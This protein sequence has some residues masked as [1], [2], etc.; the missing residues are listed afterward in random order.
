MED[1]KSQ[2][3]NETISSPTTSSQTT[4]EN[5]ASDSENSEKG[6]S[7]LHQALKRKRTDSENEHLLKRQ[8]YIATTSTNYFNSNQ[9]QQQLQQQQ[10]QQ[11][12]RN[13]VKPIF[14]KPSLLTSALTSPPK[15]PVFHLISTN[16]GTLKANHHAELISLLKQNNLQLNSNAPSSTTSITSPSSSSSSALIKPKEEVVTIKS[17]D[18]TDVKIKVENVDKV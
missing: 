16:R 10:P 9:Q 6:Q 1:A 7:L 11:Q 15:R 17:E 5:E 2:Y 8:F 13:P 4:T 18:G 14:N 12:Q 3:Q